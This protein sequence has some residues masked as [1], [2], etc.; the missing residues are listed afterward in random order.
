M[1]RRESFSLKLKYRLLL[2]IWELYCIFMLM[3]RL[4]KNI[5]I[6]EHSVTTHRVPK[7]SYSPLTYPTSVPCNA[8]PQILHIFISRIGR[9]WHLCSVP[10]ADNIRLP[11]TNTSH[12]VHHKIRSVPVCGHCRIQTVEV[13]GPG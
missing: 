5:S 4:S 8:P 1:L 13:F 7:I 2:H 3:R 6:W 10:S 11:S 12:E 9:G